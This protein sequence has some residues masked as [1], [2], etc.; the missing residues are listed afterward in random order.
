MN[1][2]SAKYFSH[3]LVGR[4]FKGVRLVPT[5]KNPGGRIEWRI[6]AK[7]DAA[8]FGVEEEA[9]CCIGMRNGEILRMSR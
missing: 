4:W 8:S 7:L 2:R 6:E 5:G 9:L 1:E 3:H